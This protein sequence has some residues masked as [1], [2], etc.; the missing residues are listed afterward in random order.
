MSSWIL[1]LRSG[2]VFSIPKPSYWVTYC[3]ELDATELQD[4]FLR[5]VST[6]YFVLC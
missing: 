2:E 4:N 6:P 5:W 3:R 1:F